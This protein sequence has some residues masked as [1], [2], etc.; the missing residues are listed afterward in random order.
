MLAQ[1]S[2]AVWD[3]TPE[4]LAV[5]A[6]E[7]TLHPDAIEPAHT[8]VL[9]DAEGELLGFHS[10]AFRPDG[11]LELEHLFVAATRLREALGRRLLWSAQEAAANLGYGSFV[12][13]S[14]PNAEGFYVAE[15]ARL[16][17]RIPSSIPGRSI[18]FLELATR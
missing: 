11:R 16:L 14:D 8:H 1:A 2:K 3:Y 5:F 17:E 10:F 4:P 9:A 18:P 7:L 15:G 13:Q 6:G 12:I